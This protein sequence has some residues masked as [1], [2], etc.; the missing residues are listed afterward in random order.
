ML[1]TSRS[2]RNELWPKRA[3]GLLICFRRPLELSQ[4]K[5]TIIL[6][7]C[8]PHSP[9]TPLERMESTSRLRASPPWP[10]AC[11]RPDNG[12]AA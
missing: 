10:N 2:A 11:S 4:E 3:F 5:S 8:D 6:L 12:G 9:S 7:L 1:T